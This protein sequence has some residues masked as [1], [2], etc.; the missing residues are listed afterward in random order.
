MSSITLLKNQ[1]DSGQFLLTTV[2]NDLNEVEFKT[3]LANTGASAAWI[4]AHL[5]VN[6][7]WFLSVLTHT[8]IECDAQ[9]I[10]NSQ[11]D[12]S[13]QTFDANLYHKEYLLSLF[14]QQRARV[15]AAL[16]KQNAD[17]WQMSAP[18]GLPTIFKTLGDT[19]GIL[20]THQYWHFGQLMSI[21]QYLGNHKDVF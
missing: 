21:R 12:L 7:D 16:E 1:L 11:P 17:T 6:E 9:I 4:F 3:K 15:L 13:Y 5:A 20:G 18:P 14:K 2:A 8:T 10:K 19:W